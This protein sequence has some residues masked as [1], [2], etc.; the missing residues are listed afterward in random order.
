MADIVYPGQTPG[1][2]LNSDAL[3]TNSDIVIYKGDYVEFF[4]PLLNALGAPIDITGWTARA[5]LKSD[6]SDRASKPFTC[7]VDDAVAGIVKVFMSSTQT[8]ELLPGSYIWDLEAENLEGEIR[9]FYAG[10]VTVYNEV[11]TV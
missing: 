9:T 1:Q 3:P 4:V 8:T 2:V 5:V 6:Y 11:T 7:T 10:D